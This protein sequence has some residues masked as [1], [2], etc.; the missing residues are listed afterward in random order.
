[1]MTPADSVDIDDEHDLEYADFVAA[2]CA[3]P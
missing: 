3:R 1:M 2:P